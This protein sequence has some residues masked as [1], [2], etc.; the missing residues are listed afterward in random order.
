MLVLS[1]TPDGAMLKVFDQ[2]CILGTD[3][4]SLPGKHVSELSTLLSAAYESQTLAEGQLYDL[5]ALQ[6]TTKS[7]GL[8]AIVPT[9]TGTSLFFQDTTDISTFGTKSP[10]CSNTTILQVSLV[11]KIEFVARHSS[12]LLNRDPNS[13]IGESI[14]RFVSDDD[15]AQFCRKVVEITKCGVASFSVKMLRPS[16]E[17][18]NTGASAD[19]EHEEETIEVD[20]W[21]RVCNGVLFFVLMEQD[22]GKHCS[23]AVAVTVAE[24]TAERLSWGLVGVSAIEHTV[25]RMRAAV[26]GVMA[27]RPYVVQM[28]FFLQVLSEIFCDVGGNVTNRAG[29]IASGILS[30]AY[31]AMQKPYTV[32][33]PRQSTMT[34]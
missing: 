4:S 12:G 30:T 17:N 9:P 29:K 11:G 6:G 19:Q 14:M 25:A 20:I 34:C 10:F 27:M 28:F 22:D 31:Y 15:L 18:S 8:F 16:P 2:H 23:E 7:V 1:L 13:L 26:D 33:F 24:A 32:V 21:G 3:I 5:K